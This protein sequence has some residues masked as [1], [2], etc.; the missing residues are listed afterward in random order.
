LVRFAKSLFDATE[1][2]CGPSRL[3]MKGS[4]AR[5]GRCGQLRLGYNH[6]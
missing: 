2:I 4:A 6:F 1:A 5:N 3:S